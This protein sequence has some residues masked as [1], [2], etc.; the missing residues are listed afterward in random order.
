MSP[1]RL[2]RGGLR[3]LRNLSAGG[4]RRLRR[5]N[6]PLRVLVVLG[7]SA[8][9]AGTGWNSQWDYPNQ[10]ADWY[11]TSRHD[12]RRD[13]APTAVDQASDGDDYG[14]G[15]DALFDRGHA[16][17][18]VAATNAGAPEYV[19][20]FGDRISEGNKCYEAA[21]CNDGVFCN[22]AEICSRTRCRAGVPP[23]CD[24]GD[25]CTS[26]FCNA[27]FDRCQFKPLSRA[28]EVTGLAVTHVD[29][30]ARLQWDVN[31]AAGYYNV[32]RGQFVD[33]TNLYCY[34]GHVA[35]T[36]L[37]DDGANPRRGIYILLVTAY[38]CGAESSAGKNSAGTE[39]NIPA[40]CP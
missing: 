13:F 3:R 25:P 4:L 32:Y 20:R 17:P 38:G 7:G 6:P 1:W 40:P 26:D 11:G 2:L 33:L 35:G 18:P 24:D 8:A 39:R 12:A 27:F 36:T 15:Y 28:P 30:T 9:M 23:V 21:D 19:F 10:G 34:Q 22:G 31:A 5:L 14:F 29:R 16:G 37:D